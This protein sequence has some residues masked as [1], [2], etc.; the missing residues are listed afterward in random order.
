M[1]MRKCCLR[2]FRDLLEIEMGL[3]SVE[4]YIEGEIEPLVSATTRSN[5]P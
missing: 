3:A 5:A 2:E 4:T 1:G